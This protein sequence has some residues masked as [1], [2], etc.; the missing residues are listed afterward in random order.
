MQQPGILQPA[1]ADSPSIGRRRFTEMPAT[2]MRLLRP[3]SAWLLRLYRS[4]A[5]PYNC[6]YSY[7]LVDSTTKN[8]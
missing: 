7:E 8:S 3:C 1:E 2:A 4:I 5:R 6:T